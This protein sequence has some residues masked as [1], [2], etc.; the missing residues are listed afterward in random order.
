MT[1]RNLGRT[2]RVLLLLLLA[3]HILPFASRPA[4]IGG[5]EVHYALMASSMGIDGDLSLEADYERV[6]AGSPAAGRKHAGQELDRH[7]IEVGDRKVFAHPLGL[8]AAAAPWIHIQHRIAPG[9]APDLLLALLSLSVTGLA[10]V[11]AYRTLGGISG[12]RPG[13]ALATVLLI[14]FSTP[15]WFYSRT[16]F[17]EPFLGSMAVLAG[18]ALVTGRWRTASFLLGALF[19]LKETA[20]LLILP[21]LAFTLHRFGFRRAACLSIGPVVAFALF[22]AKNAYVYGTPLTT[23]QPFRSGSLLDGL[24]GL[25][26]DPSNGVLFFAPTLLV[27]SLGWI[28]GAPRDAGL[29]LALRYALLAVVAWVTMTALWVDWTGG[30]SYGPR[31][32]VPIM[33]LFGLPLFSLLQSATP[34]MR[35]LVFGAGVAG[36]LVSFCAAIDPFH[37]FWSTPV[38]TIVI[39]HPLGLLLGLITIGFVCRRLQTRIHAQPGAVQVER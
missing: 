29:T 37:A 28:R 13:T 26:I 35:R 30:S 16:F 11:A 3:L 19:L 7:L 24:V 39:E 6:A 18:C 25:A 33:P 32:L 15:L 21:L 38:H 8:P 14:Y 4:L 36:F 2:D 1:R 31:L 17:T 12:A 34:G 9:A 5:D 10:L 23:F 20:V 22:C 27:A